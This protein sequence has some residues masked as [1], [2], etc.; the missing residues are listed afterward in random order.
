MTTIDISQTRAL[1]PRP[2]DQY[3]KAFSAANVATILDTYGISKTPL[4][5][6]HFMAQVLTETGRLRVLVE[7]LNYRATGLTRVGPSRFPNPAIADQYA[8]DDEKLGNYV[9]A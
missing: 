4:R 6:C 8:H 5:V 3:N 7:A 9:Y 1:A 2:I